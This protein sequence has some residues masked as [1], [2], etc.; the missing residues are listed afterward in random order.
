MKKATF[1]QLAYL[2]D[3]R[4]SGDVNMFGA[5]KYLRFEFPELTEQDGSDVVAEWMASFSQR[6]P[7]PDLSRD[8]IFLRV[9]PWVNRS[10]S[11]ERRWDARGSGGLRLR[12]ALGATGLR[13]ISNWSR[14]NGESYNL[15][16]RRIRPL[17]SC[18]RRPA[19]FL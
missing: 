15:G 8:A 11:P 1:Q 13:M 17:P 5:R 18:P 6:H 3:L 9:P 4:E 10:Q 12:R 2:D 7:E 19:A 14:N 16:L